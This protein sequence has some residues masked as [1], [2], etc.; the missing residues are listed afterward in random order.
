MISFI[1]KIVSIWLIMVVAAIINGIAR[2][3]LLFPVIGSYALPLSGISLSLLVFIICFF[4]IDVF[5]Q[6]N[7]H[8]YFIIGLSWV[9]MTLLFEYLFGHFITGKSW[10]EINQVFNLARGDLFILVLLITIVAPWVSAKLR[11]LL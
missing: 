11:Q 7:P 8:S 1:T 5:N 4:S 3:K 6:L 9:C 2:D 10:Q